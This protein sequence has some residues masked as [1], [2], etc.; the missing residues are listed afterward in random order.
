MEKLK[1]FMIDLSKILSHL[2]KDKIAELETVTERI[3]QTEKAEI[4]LLF[5]SY[6][7]GDYKLERGKESG[8]MQVQFRVSTKKK[9]NSWQIFNVCAVYEGIVLIHAQNV[10]RFLRNFYCSGLE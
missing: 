7:R 8:K 10:H 9:E 1:T 3:V 4:I 2:P 5:G 6:A